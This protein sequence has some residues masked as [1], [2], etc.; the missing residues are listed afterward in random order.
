MF[1]QQ[2]LPYPD[3]E[4]VSFL[5]ED[6]SISSIK[7]N[8][9][10]REFIKEKVKNQAS[11]EVTTI[12]KEKPSYTLKK[13]F[14]IVFTDNFFRA[15]AGGVNQTEMKILA[16]IIDQMEYGNLISISQTSIARATDLK[17]SNV[18]Y[19]FRN[20]I[21]KNILIK[22]DGNIFVNSNI[23]SKGL[24]RRL[25]KSKYDNLKKAQKTT[26]VIEEAF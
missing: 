3:D 18:S 26:Q 2:N 4:E 13:A 11:V 17:R 25:E 5:D 24:S 16:Y 14:C 9:E 1:N 12:V 23:I 22:K 15:I 6:P 10:S 21:L 19:A 20:L 8:K 7:L